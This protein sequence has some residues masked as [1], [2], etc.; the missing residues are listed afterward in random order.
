MDNTFRNNQLEI[1]QSL[2]EGSMRECARLE[3]R[4]RRQ[5]L[6]GA[7][8]TVLT[9]RNFGNGIPVARLVRQ[10]FPVDDPA[11]GP[12]YDCITELYPIEALLKQD[13]FE[14]VTFQKHEGTRFRFT[15][16]K[17]VW[18]SVEP[19]MTAPEGL[20]LRIEWKSPLPKECV[21]TPATAAEIL[22][23]TI[24]QV[25]RETGLSWRPVVRFNGEQLDY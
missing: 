15:D 16:G 25:K 2:V 9:L 21:L 10:L 22:R 23:K 20:L 14:L 7:F 12:D 6:L 18:F 8:D 5:L 17:Q 3:E 24:S 11:V 4:A 13:V 1:F 19:D